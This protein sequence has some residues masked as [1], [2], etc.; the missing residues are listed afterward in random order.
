MAKK[1]L[2][3]AA[4]EAAARSR[5]M[6]KKYPPPTIKTGPKMDTRGT[7]NVQPKVYEGPRNTAHPKDVNL[8]LNTGPKKKK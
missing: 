7:S 4:Q 2:A 8:S 5:E 3:E 1:S 6:N